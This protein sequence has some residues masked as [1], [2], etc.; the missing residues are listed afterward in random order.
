[1]Y[2][3]GSLQDDAPEYA[4]L[5]NA[6][7]LAGFVEEYTS[8]ASAYED[9]TNVFVPYYRQAGMAVMK[10]SWLETGNVYSAVS[11]IPYK[12]ITAALDYYF[13]NCNDGRPFIIA[14]H[15]QG[16]AITMLVLMQYFKEHQEYYKRMIAAYP[17]GYSVPKMKTFLLLCCFR[18]QSAST[19]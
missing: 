11:G 15:S 3:L 17:I 4:T 18:A 13:T 8:Q 9:S 19:R 2:V 10:K 5:D 1:M 16:S 14:G 12:D 7:M 6:E